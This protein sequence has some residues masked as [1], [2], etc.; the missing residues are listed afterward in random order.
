MCALSI[1]IM[2]FGSVVPFATFAIPAIAS[3]SVLY[4]V[5]EFGRGA[6]MLVYTVIA[7]LSVLFVPEKE[8]A[9]LFAFFFGYYPVLKGL[10]EQKLASVWCWVCKFGVFIVSITSMYL[11]ITQLFV[12]ESVRDEFAQYGAAMFAALC[13]LGLIMFFCFDFALTR[14]LSFYIYRIR[15]KITKQ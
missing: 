5:I 10:F 1:A 9:L 7:V 6:G 8:A 11:I 2:F 4:M 14:L 12:I 13:V 15:P 3:L